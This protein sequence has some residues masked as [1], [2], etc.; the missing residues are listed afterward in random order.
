MQSARNFQLL[1]VEINRA[2]ELERLHQESLAE[3]AQV[4][5]TK[6]RLQ[7]EVWRFRELLEEKA[8]P[9]PNDLLTK[10]M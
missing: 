9:V 2:R 7:H 5:D 8:I 6:I 3:V 1:R 4:E 10:S